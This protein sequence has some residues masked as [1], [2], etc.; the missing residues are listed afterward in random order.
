VTRRSL[1]LGCAGAA[2][3]LAAA[4]LLPPVAGAHG[5]VGRADLPIPTWLFAWA[6]TIVLGASF[7][8]LAA[9]WREPRLEQPSERRLMRIPRVVD[10]ACGALGIGFFVVVVYA[11]F[12]GSAVPTANIAPTSI[13]VIFWVGSVVLGVLFG[14]V[15]RA[16]NPWRSF[17]VAVAWAA[18]PLTRGRS[19]RT[20][21]YPARLGR[22]PA[23]LGIL[24]FAWL[25]LAYPPTERTDPSQL[26]VIALVYAG[27]QLAAMA[28]YGIEPWSRRGDAFGVYFNLFARLS[29][30]ERR[31]GVLYLRPPLGGA[32]SWDGSVAGSVALVCVGIGSTSFDGFSNGAAWTDI[33]PHLQS[34]FSDVGAGQEL[35]LELASTVGLLFFVGLV[36]L[37]YRLGIQGMRTVGRGHEPRELMG[38]FA[39]SLIPIAFAYAVA[40]Y[41]SLLVYQSQAMAYLISDPLGKGSD[42]FGTAGNGID[43]NV[44]SG[45]GIWYVQVGALVCGHVAGLVL[46]HDRALVTYPEPREATR[47][48][49]WM[50]VVM[51]GFTSLGLWLLSAVNR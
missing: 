47:S 40:H 23:A 3:A 26:A 36:A 11:G 43:Y 48:Q 33:S 7:A 28:V 24:A 13:Y 19:W 20:R 10:A 6:A 51:V 37:F 45:T 1:R 46:A 16:F 5:L 41:F 8:A 12:A 22:W 9:L 49:Y 34:F 29:P 14:D 27:V 31:E 38:R 17:A 2:A 42:I 30:W 35:A 15:F 44:I 50:L 32:P 21:P 39:H 4:A 18:R 25:E